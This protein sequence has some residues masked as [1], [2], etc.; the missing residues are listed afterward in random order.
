MIN[1]TW[2]NLRIISQYESVIK[3]YR[4]DVITGLLLFLANSVCSI[5]FFISKNYYISIFSGILAIFVAAIGIWVFSEYRKAK[6]QLKNFKDSLNNPVEYRSPSNYPDREYAVAG[7]DDAADVPD[8]SGGPDDSDDS[9]AD[10]DA[11]DV[12]DFVSG[13]SI[14]DTPSQDNNSDVPWDV[15]TPSYSPSPSSSDSGSSSSSYDSSS[16]SSS[17]YDSGSSCDSS[18]SF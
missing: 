10:V 3:R 16:S 9:G 2:S 15:D 17:S 11:S 5:N 8:F 18:S 13:L 6:K 4:N 1:L 7:V 14:A 12:P